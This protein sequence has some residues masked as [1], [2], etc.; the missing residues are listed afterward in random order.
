[1]TVTA[2][3][4]VTTRCV[5]PPAYVGTSKGVHLHVSLL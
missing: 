2:A 3:L 4:P 1:M 5:E